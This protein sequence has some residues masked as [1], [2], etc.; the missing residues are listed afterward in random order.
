MVTMF[1][2]E[3]DCGDG[4]REAFHKG[5][6]CSAFVELMHETKIVC[7]QYTDTLLRKQQPSFCLR[8]NQKPIKPI[9]IFTTVIL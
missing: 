5:K 1:C 3:M 4:G 9:I 2:Y 8:K 7:A 6:G